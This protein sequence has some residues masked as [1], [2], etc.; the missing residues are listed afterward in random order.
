MSDRSF[1]KPLVLLCSLLVGVS[2]LTAELVFTDSFERPDGSSTED[3]AGNGWTTN[4]AWRA[5]GKKQVFLN[6]G[7]LEIR[8]LEHANHAV[9]LKHDFPL[10]DCTISMRFKIDHG[11]R[12]GV[13]FNDTELKTAHAGHVCSVRVTTKEVSVADQ[14]TGSMNSELRKRRQAGDTSA[15]LKRLIAKTEKKSPINLAPNTWH[16][17]MFELEDDVVRVF[18]NGTFQLEHQSPGFAHPTKSN[19]ALSLPKNL[20][21][22]DFKVWD[23]AGKK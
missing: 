11:D 14:M 1:L 6:N 16:E 9:S 18:L 2:S 15:E 22:D 17:L 10:G 12:L 21:V 20:I 13:N 5:D 8:R 4:S 23:Q 19:I 7:V 3:A